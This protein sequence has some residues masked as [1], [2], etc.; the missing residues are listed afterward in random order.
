[1]ALFGKKEEKNPVPW[2][3]KSDEKKVDT[4]PRRCP[5]KGCMFS[6]STNGVAVHMKQVHQK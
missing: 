6:S 3:K 5:Y 1:M 2:Y 4:T